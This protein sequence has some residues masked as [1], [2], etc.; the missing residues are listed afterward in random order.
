VPWKENGQVTKWLGTITDVDLIVCRDLTERKQEE[1]FRTGQS[2]ILE[3]I[4][5][6]EP[7]ESVLTS[8][9]L[10]IE[11]QAEEMLCSILLLSDDGEHVRHGAAPSLPTDY[12]KAVDGAPI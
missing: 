6:S 12:V 5:R 4:A 9:M 3:M 2:H 8:L 10:L 11:A 7:L 1:A